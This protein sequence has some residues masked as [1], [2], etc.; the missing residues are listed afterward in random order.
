MSADLYAEFIPL[1]A[2]HS[3]TVVAVIKGQMGRVAASG[4][5]FQIM[6]GALGREATTNNSVAEVAS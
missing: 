6:P 1:P 4:H 2:T 5:N 3:P